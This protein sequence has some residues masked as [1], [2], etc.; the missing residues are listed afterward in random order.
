MRFSG[1]IYTMVLVM[2][3]VL[4]A[5][6]CGGGGVRYDPEPYRQHIEG[7]ESILQKPAAEM[8]DGGRIFGFAAQLAGDLGQKIENA[9]KKET[10]KSLLLEFGQRLSDREAGGSP[11]DLDEARAAWQPLRDSL[12]EPADWFR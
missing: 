7:L 4:V 1:T 11:I 9:K 12:F 6:G 8:G 3:S 5:A 2:G 10:V